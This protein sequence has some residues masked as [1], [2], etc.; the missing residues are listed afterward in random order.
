MDLF[1]QPN[2][3]DAK[4]DS[5]PLAARMRPQSL[6]DFAGQAHILG[7]GKLLRRAVESDRLGSII[8]YEI[9][10]AHV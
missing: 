4:D 10:R 5:A 7:P 1:E 2:R 9:G 8:L 3:D 6:D